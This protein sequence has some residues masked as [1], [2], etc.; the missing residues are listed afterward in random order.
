MFFVHFWCCKMQYFQSFP[1]ASPPGPPP[2]PC[3]GPAGGLKALPRPPAARGNDL[4]VI[5]YRASY[6]IIP[7]QTYPSPSTNSYTQSKTLQYPTNFSSIFGLLGRAENYSVEKRITSYDYLTVGFWLV[8]IT[9]R[10]QCIIGFIRFPI[11]I[12]RN[13]TW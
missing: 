5:A 4:T 6:T 9:I 3:P 13:S 7:T 1:G 2:G 10:V 12:P 11:R 8:I